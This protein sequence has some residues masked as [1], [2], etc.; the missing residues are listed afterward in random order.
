[1]K[2]MKTNVASKYVTDSELH[3]VSLSSCLPSHPYS[4]SF[5]GSGDTLWAPLR[6]PKD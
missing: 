4:D 3:A 1:M 5:S 6:Q 2:F